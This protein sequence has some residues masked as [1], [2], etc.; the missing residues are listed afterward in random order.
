MA[1]GV[2]EDIELPHTQEWE[3]YH[4]DFSLC[5]KKTRGCLMELGLDFKAHHIDLIETGSYENISRHYLTVNPGALVPVLVHNGHPVYES[6]EQLVYAAKHASSDANELL[7]TDPK[8]LELMQY[9]V[10]KSSLVGDDP[11]AGCVKPRVTL[12]PG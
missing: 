2:R 5:S 6:H 12:P 8:Q 9:W 1:G 3:L 7:P 10:H 4:N 11:I